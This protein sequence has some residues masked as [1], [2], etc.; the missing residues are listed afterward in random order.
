MMELLAGLERQNK[1]LVLFE[2]FVLIGIIGFLDYSTGYEYAFSVFYLIPIFLI[3]W[4][5]SRS[6]GYAA[7]LASA[8]VWLIADKASGNLYSSSFIP[9]WNTLMRFAFFVITTFQLSS[10]RRLLDREKELSN[11]DY[12]TG[13]ANARYFYRIVQIEKER[14]PRYHR[15]FTIA[16]VDI[17][18]FKLVNDQYGHAVGDQVLQT[19]VS[20]VQKQI[21]RSDL[22]ARLG[23]DEF[24]LFF[25]E[26]DQDAA[27]IVLPK[28]N[29]ALV[30]DLRKKNW[31]ITFS[32]GVV[33]FNAAPG[34]TDDVVKI[35]D[36]LM[37][38]A[39]AGGKNTVNYFTYLG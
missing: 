35:A 9:I 21:R 19:V 32:M 30:E 16:Y 10:L 15:S 3:T 17:D 33:T 25:P 22:I 28:M 14:L 13:A 12:L 29:N 20:A 5:T 37:Y 7:S 18:N 27:R 4:L 24:A 11:T 23:G 8:S 34:T 26:T 31:A 1:S 36:E 39:K 6:W 38:S 2:G